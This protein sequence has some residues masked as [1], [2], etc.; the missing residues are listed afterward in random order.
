MHKIELPRRSFIGLGLGSA[1]QALL[2]GNASASG[3]PNPNGRAKRVLVL[4]EQ[5]GVS[6][7][8]TWDPK[9]D[10]PLE[11]RSPFK[12][13]KTSVEGFYVTELLSQTARLAKHLAVVRC[14]T[15]PTPG[16]GNSHPKGSQYV[17]SGEAPDGPVEMPDIGS[18]VANRLGTT[19]PYLPANILLPGTDE[20]ADSSRIGFLPPGFSAF[21]TGGSPANPAWRVANLGLLLGIDEKRFLNRHDL[22]SNLDVGFNHTGQPKDVEAMRALMNQATDMLTNP[23][24]RKA[25]DLTTEPLSVRERYGIGHR[26][27]CYLLG[28]KLIESGVRYVTVDVREPQSSFRDGKPVNYPGG[29]NMNWDH[30][31]AIYSTSHTN[32]PNGGAG[33]GRYGIGTWP[34]MGSLDRAFSALIEDLN[35]SGLL[36]DTLVCL[37]SEFGRTPRINERQ[38]RD[39]WTHAFSYAFA[40]AGVPGGQV[41]GSTDRDGGYIASS[42]AYTLE[43]YAATIYEKLGIDRTKPLYTPTNRPIF[44]A[45]KGK[46]I[47]ELF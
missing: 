36:N 25:F 26:G 12:T 24:T 3:R 42:M 5:G 22:L 40:G 41:I 18:V 15:Q 20:Q 32:I 7:T 28:R 38:G 16:I 17:Y 19:T 23:K 14:M 43:D 8:D 47:P 21:K 34:M 1:L 29:D 6:H 35:R 33:A 11:H 30:H 27:Q 4:F 31:D 9:P 39:H 44:I 46:P 2:H 13:I 45:A 37:V 10:A